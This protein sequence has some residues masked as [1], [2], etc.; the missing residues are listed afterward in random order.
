MLRALLELCS[1]FFQERRNASR[2]RQKRCLH[3]WRKRSLKRHQH[4]TGTAQTPSVTVRT[5][6]R[7]SCA[8][9]SCRRCGAAMVPSGRHRAPLSWH[10]AAREQHSCGQRTRMQSCREFWHWR[11]VCCI[12][13]TALL[14]NSL[15]LFLFCSG[16]E[17]C[18]S[19]LT[20]QVV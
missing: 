4:A 7:P 3:T 18:L 11:T 6:R 13:H 19:L 8:A 17:R 2:H 20:H 5:M 9:W 1:F 10:C 12:H 14:H 16:A 15:H